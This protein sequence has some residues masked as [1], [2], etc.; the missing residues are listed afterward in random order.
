MEDT[1]KEILSYFRV[2]N[3]ADGCPQTGSS[4]VTMDNIH[5]AILKYDMKKASPVKHYVIK[6][7]QI[8]IDERNKRARQYR[9]LRDKKY[10]ITETYFDEN[11]LNNYGFTEDEKTVIT[12]RLS[13][14]YMRG[15]K[16]KQWTYVRLMASIKDK[17]T[18]YT[19]LHA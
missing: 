10:C 5:E 2:T 17:I 11:V 18:R 7:K 8:A 9:L 15:S 12:E 14:V 1:Y 16:F 19:G 6:A 3:D 4:Y 13:G